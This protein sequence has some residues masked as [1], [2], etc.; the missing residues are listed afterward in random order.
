MCGPWVKT[1]N[2]AHTNVRAIQCSVCISSDNPHSL[3]FNLLY[4]CHR[5]SYYYSLY[6]SYCFC[7][8][9]LNDTSKLHRFTGSENGGAE[10]AQ[11]EEGEEGQ[12]DVSGEVQGEG[13]EE[14]G[15]EGEE[16]E[17]SIN[18]TR[19]HSVVMNGWKPP[20][21]EIWAEWG[22]AGAPVPVPV[23][24]PSPVPAPVTRNENQ[25]QNSRYSQ[26][27]ESY[28]SDRYRDR[29][30]GVDRNQEQVERMRQG[31]GQGRVEVEELVEEDKE[32]DKEGTVTGRFRHLL[33]LSRFPPTAQLNEMTALL[34]CPVGRVSVSVNDDRA[35]VV[36][37]VAVYIGESTGQ[38]EKVLLNALT[39]YKNWTKYPVENPYYHL[40]NSPK[41]VIQNIQNS[42]IYV[43][44]FNRNSPN[45]V[46]QNTSLERKSIENESVK[47]HLKPGYGNEN[48]E[49]S[50]P[51][52]SSLPLPH[53]Y[54]SPPSLSITKTTHIKHHLQPK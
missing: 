2:P 20:L 38:V 23:P 44:Q 7:Y 31:K 54:P 36:L 3:V 49:S 16:L 17:Y 1:E 18:A 12:G 39:P 48:N 42:P 53:P 43:P 35:D 33:G 24:V 27:K 26:N 8:L 25:L 15:E 40:Q 30:S 9:Q 41:S 19:M 22:L 52:S 29:D 6:L 34:V 10:G 32:E 51:F 4:R 45:I 46:S 50:I 28:D 37:V 11:V 21:F 5:Y 13:I 47:S 14:E